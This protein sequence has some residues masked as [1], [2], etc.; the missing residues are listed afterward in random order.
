M[1]EE[2]RQLKGPEKLAA[3]RELSSRYGCDWIEYDESISHQLP[4]LLRLDLEKLKKDG[5]FPHAVKDD[6]A[7][8]IACK[9]GRELAAEVKRILGV[10]TVEFLVTLPADLIR[11]VEHNQDVNVGFS[12]CSGR[13]PLARVRTHLAGR[14]SLFAHYRTLLAKSRTG[15]AFIRTGLACIT[16]ALLF[17]RIFGAGWWLLLE[18]PLLV[19]GCV[20]VFDGLKWYLPARQL[21][22]KLP[23]CIDTGATGGTTV[24][25][26]ANEKDFP[27]FSRT[28]ETTG[29]RKLR[30]SWTSLSPVM[31]RRY[32][33]SDR[34]DYAE[35]RTVLACM[36]THMAKA[37]TGLAFIRTGIAFASLGFGLVRHF[38]SSHWLAFDLALMAVGAAMVAE[39]F[40]WYPS[41]RKAG[42][43]GNASVKR[44]FGDGSIWDYFFPH[45][46]IAPGP[47]SI[48]LTLP[49][50][51]SDLPGVWATTGVA[52]E[53]TVL[54]E[55]RNVMSR[56]RTIMARERTGFAFIRT[57]RSFIFIG[58]AFIL[59]FGLDP[60]GWNIFNWL[61]V[62]IGLLLVADGLYWSLPAE[63]QRRQFPY[64]FGDLDITIPDYGTPGRFWRR[65]VFSHE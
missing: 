21:K 28:D 26:V 58:I 40:L 5:W 47:S 13:T 53:R 35:E 31:R 1:E 9:P 50:R 11:M 7:T 4:L 61:M 39:G 14:R 24:L 23:V 27:V 49:V 18:G 32:L 38:H 44:S 60:L 51:S 46:H 62:G 16:I 10:A 34:T 56:L 29:A 36:R 12:A 52:L 33:A 6:K 19:A 54:A 45:R 17:L 22:T 2:V 42:V 8:I 64:C 20:M 63:R 25:T 59:F 57:G 65:V 30:S 48:P 43:E 55:R 41:G 15:L 37:R 3:L